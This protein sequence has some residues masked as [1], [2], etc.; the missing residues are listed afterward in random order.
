MD[1]LKALLLYLTLATGAAVG[2]TESTPIPYELLHTPTPVVTASPTPSPVPTPSPSPTPRLVTL[3]EGDSGTYVRQ[4][5]T[6]LAEL[7]YLQTADI[8]GFYGKKTTAAV[9]TFQ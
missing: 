6:R 9:R 4:M 7:G 1:F 2:A 5:Q 3:S 8:D